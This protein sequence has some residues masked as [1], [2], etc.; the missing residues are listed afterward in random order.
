MQNI[1]ATVVDFDGNGLLILGKSGTGKSD[2]ALRLICDKGAVLVSDDR[3]DIDLQNG[4]LIACAPEALAGL[5]EVYSLGIV[6]LP[7]KKTTEIKLVIELCDHHEIERMPTPSFFNYENIKI[8]LFKLDP[9]EQSSL[10]KIVV[11][12]NCLLEQ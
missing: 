6:R 5:L 10:D 3:T 7:F 12:L 11:K 2:L 4:S 1:H 8:P 9:F